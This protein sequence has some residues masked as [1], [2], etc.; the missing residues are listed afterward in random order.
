MCPAGRVCHFAG[1]CTDTGPPP[2]HRYS[3]FEKIEYNG[4][5]VANDFECPLLT[6]ILNV[7]FASPLCVDC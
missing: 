4:E 7:K 1:V 3:E 6:L 5:L 2:V